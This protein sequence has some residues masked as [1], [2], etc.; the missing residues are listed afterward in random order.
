M[1]N[2]CSICH[3]QLKSKA[4]LRNHTDTT[5]PKL[6]KAHVCRKCDRPFCS[7]KAMESHRDSPYHITFSCDVCNKSFGSKQAIEAHQKSLRHTSAV[8][9]AE[10]EGARQTLVGATTSAGNVSLDPLV[11]QK[12]VVRLLKLLPGFLDPDGAS[13]T[14]DT[15]KLRLEAHR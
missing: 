10:K 6:R 7:Q 11:N 3:K 2:Q 1:A 14:C 8:K 5:D 15:F 4:A 12:S 9:R 13:Y